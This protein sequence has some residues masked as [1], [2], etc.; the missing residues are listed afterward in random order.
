MSDRIARFVPASLTGRPERVGFLLLAGGISL[1]LVSIAASQMLLAAAILA[2]L[3]QWRRVDFRELLPAAIVWPT[4]LLLSWTILATVAG[5]GSLRDGLVK[6]LWLY[7]ILFLVPIF[8]RGRGR[9]RWIYYASFAVGAVSAA[10]GLIQYV[11]DPDRDALNRIKGF[12]S[13]W[14]T[15]SGSL[16][17]IMVATVAYGCIYG[18]R[19]N[20]WVVPLGLGLGAALFLSQ[21]RNAWLG[22]FLGIVLIFFMLKR[23]RALTLMAAALLAL[24]FVL[25][26]N[27]E[28]RLKASWNL[29][30]DN[31][32]NRIELFGAGFR[33]IKDH[34]WI[35]VG[36]RVSLEAPHYRGSTTF[37]DWMYIHLHN[38]FLQI[39]AERGIPGLML[40]LWFMAQ[41]GLQA[42]RVFGASEGSGEA[43]FAAAAAL[44][45]WVA[46][47]AGGMFEYNF[48]DSEV[49]T[50][51]LFMMS[52]P[53]QTRA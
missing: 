43:G 6:K 49:L 2:A 7:S 40:W 42:F 21:T 35:G 14:M 41:L 50:I 24:Y 45:A 26:A 10:C 13:I 48:G 1:A 25:P 32:R 3:L 30:D 44:G 18:C 39:A 38:N 27:I 15:F 52:A 12:M 23:W 53:L 34:P 22:A 11:M 51:F 28:Q 5:G 8:A 29:A 20:A 4:V 17:L 16:M 31:T 37:P 33:L 19:R 9:V 47:L 36:Q 46:L